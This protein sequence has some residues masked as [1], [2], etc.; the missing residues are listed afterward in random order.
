[1]EVLLAKHF[2]NPT[3]IQ[4]F[5]GLEALTIFLTVKNSY[6]ELLYQY[7]IRSYQQSLVFNI[8]RDKQQD[9]CK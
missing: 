5:Y 7:F 9:V 2:L 6:L 8:I 4:K 3:S 1:M